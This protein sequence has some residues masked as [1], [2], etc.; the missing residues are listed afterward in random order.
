M[1]LPADP[2]APLPGGPGDRPVKIVCSHADRDTELAEELWTCL[3]PL[4]R[5]RQIEV[6][7]RGTFLAG[8]VSDACMR[9]QLDEAEIILLLFSPDYLAGDLSYEEMMYALTRAASDGV[10]IITITLRACHT[11]PIED[12]LAHRACRANKEP[13]VSQ[14]NR[15][16]AWQE[17]VDVIQHAVDE[18]HDG[19]QCGH[20]PVGPPPGRPPGLSARPSADRSIYELLKNMLGTECALDEF[21]RQYFERVHRLFRPDIAWSE[22]LDLLFEHA[23][24][25]RIKERLAEYDPERYKRLVHRSD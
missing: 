18:R 1:T 22:R 7:H 17:V 4:E 15:D 25:D 16:E 23:D 24:H 5:N 20:G 19:G 14:P 6:W 13:I 11:K 8:S 12:Q 21:C 10:R 2:H 3:T 9:Q